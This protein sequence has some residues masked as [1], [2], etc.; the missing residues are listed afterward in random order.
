MNLVTCLLVFCGGLS[1]IKTITGQ[2]RFAKFAPFVEHLIK[3]RADGIVESEY[4]P[5]FLDAVT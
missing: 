3:Q 5:H 2:F 4:F 1:Q